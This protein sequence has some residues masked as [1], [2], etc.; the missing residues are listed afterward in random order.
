MNKTITLL[1]VGVI[2]AA[3]LLI[4]LH[5]FTAE[6]NTATS[7][8][9]TARPQSHT[10]SPPE[11]TGSTGA[12][13]PPTAS[14]PAENTPLPPPEGVAVRTVPAQIDP[15]RPEARPPAASSDSARA[16]APPPPPAAPKRPSAVA[17]HFTNIVVLV[18]QEGATVRIAADRPFTHKAILLADPDRLALDFEGQWNVSTPAVPANKLVKAIRVGK[19]NDATRLVIDLH[20]KPDSRRLIKN[21]PQS[22]D[23]RLR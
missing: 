6:E 18:T 14:A 9:V 4:L 11:N 23:V 21:S 8:A 15:D 7:V 10:P 22:L 13:L 16:S 1:I 17:G 20:K 3:L 19:Q 12:P 5:S 2:L